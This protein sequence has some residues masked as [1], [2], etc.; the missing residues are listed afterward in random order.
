MTTN[1]SAR[2]APAAALSRRRFLAGLGCAASAGACAMP[3]PQPPIAGVRARRFADVDPSYSAIYDTHEDGPYV[4]DAVDLSQIDPRFLRA[5]VAYAGA[6]APGS[7]VVDVDKR[8][9]YFVM[10]G[11]RAMRYG[12]GVG[13][14]EAFNFKGMA[15]IQRKAEWP[16]WIPTPDMIRRDP[17][18]Y[19]P[20]RGGMDGGPENP[21]G[22]R[23]LY[24]Y[25][26]GKDTYYRLHGTN[27]P[28][29]IGT[30]VS[31]GCVRLLNQD[32]IDL[33]DRVPVGT[34]V[35]VRSGKGRGPKV[36]EVAA[37]PGFVPPEDDQF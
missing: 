35:D 17:E 5:E 13:R 18:R 10:P 29:S 25:R 19:E 22:A 26:G 36:E 28:N 8:H 14:E 4:V 31:S 37:A 23:A 24:L 27:E 32:V 1:I 20:Y 33:Y 12:V 34:R 3:P 9:L 11:G 30:M 2:P 6:E 21:L 16:R 15:V 7:I